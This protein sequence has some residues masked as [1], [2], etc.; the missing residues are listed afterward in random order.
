M[1]CC[2]ALC[3]C[4]DG[5]RDRSRRQFALIHPLMYSVQDSKATGTL[6]RE[7]IITAMMVRDDRVTEY[8]MRRTFLVRDAVGAVEMRFNQL[9]MDWVRAVACACVCVCVRV[10][11]LCVLCLVC[12]CLVCVCVCVL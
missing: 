3:D 12:V 5:A 11:A 2:C 10:C 6:V 1:Y 7:A 9:P 8:L 4:G